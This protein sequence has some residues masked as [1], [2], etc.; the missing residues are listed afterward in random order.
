ME[1][2]CYEYECEGRQVD[3]F[4]RPGTTDEN[5]LKEVIDQHGYRRPSMGFEILP[6]EL[7]L[8]LGGNIGAFAAYCH[9]MGAYAESYEPEPECFKLLKRNIGNLSGFNIHETAITD[10]NAKH[11]PFYSGSRES[12][13]YRY[14]MVP[15]NHP[16][17]VKLPNTHAR[18]LDRRRF[19]GIKMDIEGAEFG[20]IEGGWLPHCKKL[21]ME[22]HFSR[23]KSISN[24]HAR[25]NRLKKIFCT[26]QYP[27]ELDRDYPDDTFKG[28]FDRLV[29]CMHPK[30]KKRENHKLEDL[31]ADNGP[32]HKLT[33]HQDEK[34]LGR[35]KFRR[36][37]TKGGKQTPGPTGK[38][39]TP[40]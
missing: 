36:K 3:M 7:W 14:S 37:S 8:D 17:S 11:L 9:L 1:T 5:V 29:W 13:K 32:K 12:D 10:V 16:M 33:L 31:T 40:K 39:K 25:I 23:D 27:A 19:D 2:A 18:I 6:D 38:R 26:V 28:H 30:R 4:Y 22:Y 15:N 34:S 21:V 35:P 20:L 24:F